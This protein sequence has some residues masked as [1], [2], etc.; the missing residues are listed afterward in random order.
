MKQFFWGPQKRNPGSFW[1][2][3][4]PTNR[5]LFCLSGVGLV[6]AAA[7]DGDAQIEM[8]RKPAAHAG[9]AK[10]LQRWVPLRLSQLRRNEVSRYF[11]VCKK[12]VNVEYNG[13]DL[14]FVGCCVEEKNVGIV[15]WNGSRHPVY[16]GKER[17]H[18]DPNVYRPDLGDRRSRRCRR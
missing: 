15:K 8:S 5:G 12:S 16:A 6:V 9:E 4:P 10:R 2:L 11:R 13:G 3:R 18:Y 7:C 17:P 1:A 14:W